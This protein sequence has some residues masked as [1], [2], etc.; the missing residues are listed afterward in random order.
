MIPATVLTIF[1]YRYI[2]LHPLEDGNGRIARLLPNYILSR[3][4]YPM[5]VVRNRKKSE[6]LDALHRTDLT[7]GEVPSLG[8]S[9]PSA[10]LMRLESIW[11]LST[12]T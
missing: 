9:L 10:F 6:Y 3:H 7:V 2:R 11:L 4:G 8:T 12:S 1:H 5:V